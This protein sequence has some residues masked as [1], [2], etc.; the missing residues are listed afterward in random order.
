MKRLLRGLRAFGPIHPQMSA[1]AV[2]L[3]AIGASVILVITAFGLSLTAGRTAT[4]A[5]LSPFGGTALILIA[6]P[7]SPQSQPWPVVVGIFL[8]AL[9]AEAVIWLCPAPL[10]LWGLPLC[11]AVATLLMAATR[12]IHAPGGAVALT[13]GLLAA[14]GRAPDFSFPFT[15]AGAG[16]LMLVVLA[17]LWHRLLGNLYP[18]RH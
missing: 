4:L 12:S 17:I 18:Q 15:R 8:S 9:S 14:E 7:E 16:A 6:L 1:R 3:A 11:V 10:P 13:V 5:L 2:V